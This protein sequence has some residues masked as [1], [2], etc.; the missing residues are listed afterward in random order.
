MA[1]SKPRAPSC[2]LLLT[3]A[4]RDRRSSKA[5][6]EPYGVPS[7]LGFLCTRGPSPS[8]RH[9]VKASPRLDSE[10]PLAGPANA[11]PQLPMTVEMVPGNLAPGIE[12]LRTAKPEPVLEPGTVAAPTAAD[13][14]QDNLAFAAPEFAEL[15]PTV[16]PPTDGS[17]S[18]NSARFE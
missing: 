9:V 12:A 5:V 16:A 10:R 2:E 15:A 4:A 6:P 17:C 13:S 7:T 1:S 11:E 18:P 3:I 14:A 8:T